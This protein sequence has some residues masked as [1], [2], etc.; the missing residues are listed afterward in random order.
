MSKKTAPRPDQIV[1]AL[2]EKIAKASNEWVGFVS[3]ANE[4][5]YTDRIIEGIVEDAR[6]LN[7]IHESRFA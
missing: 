7:E 5:A 4:D 3:T 6:R 1:R 2:V